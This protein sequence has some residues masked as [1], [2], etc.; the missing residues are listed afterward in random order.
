MR[1]V[2]VREVKEAPAI[3]YALLAERER[4]SWISH[5][6]MPQVQ[7]H[8][9]FVAAHPFRY[10]FLIEE[11][12]MHVGALECTDRN[13]VGIAIFRR[14]RGKGYGTRALTLFLQTHA[15]LPPIKAVRNGKWLAHIAPD[16]ERSKQFFARN[17]FERK[18]Q[19]TF[20]HA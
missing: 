19:E 15:P 5:C 2:D 4:E 1:L 9:E 7:E 11:M 20:I 3:L 17:G 16:N 12:G 14:F 8:L 18:I 13:E 10:W 6:E